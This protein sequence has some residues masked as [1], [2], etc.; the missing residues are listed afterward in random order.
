MNFYERNADVLYIG[1]VL[2]M[3]IRNFFQ[4]TANLGIFH[5]QSSL[6]FDGEWEGFE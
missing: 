5:N 6:F 4:I 3:R 2:L 1:T